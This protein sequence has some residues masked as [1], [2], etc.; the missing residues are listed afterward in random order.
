MANKFDLTKLEDLADG[1]TSQSI[2]LSPETVF[3]CLMAL[4]DRAQYR[5]AWVDD[6]D[7]ISDSRWDEAENYIETAKAELQVAID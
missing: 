3:L 7:T 2:D 1:F 4:N 6:D 5:G